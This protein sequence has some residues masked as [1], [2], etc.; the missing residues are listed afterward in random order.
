MFFFFFLFGVLLASE[1]DQEADWQAALVFFILPVLISFKLSALFGGIIGIA[2]LIIFKKNIDYHLIKLFGL[3]CLFVLIPFLLRNVILSGHLL[4]PLHSLDVFDFDWKIPRSWLISYT[5]GI[6]AFVRVPIGNWP[7]YKNAPIKIWFK[8]WWVNQD[9]P[10]KMFLLILWVLLPFFLGQIIL[11]IRRKSDPNLIVLWLSAFM[12]SI[13]WFYAAPAV[14][15]G[16]GYL[17][18]TLL[19]GLILLVRAKITTGVILS[20]AACMAIYG[21]NGIYKQINRTNFSLI[22]PHKYS[23]PVIGVRQIG[24]LKVRVAI[25][26]GRC[27]NEPI[28]CTYPIPHPGLEMRGKEIEDGFRTAKD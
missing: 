22:W 19:I 4:Y 9:R 27:W 13:V 21:I 14:R 11:N 5:D 8:I 7:S 16:Y 15:F 2:W 20:L 25:E 23:K 17:I 10:D 18:P 24:N 26:D 12:A 6:A 28:P 3:Q 1:K